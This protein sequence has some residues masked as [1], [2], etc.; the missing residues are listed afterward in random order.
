M[1][2]PHP[3]S[4]AT[5]R[6]IARKDGAFEVEVTIPDAPATRVTGL[7]TKADAERWIAKHK[8]HVAAGWPRRVFFRRGSRASSDKRTERVRP[9]ERQLRA[10]QAIQANARGQGGDLEVFVARECEAFGWVT[11]VDGVYRLTEDGTRQ[12]DERV[13]KPAYR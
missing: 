12:L 2:R 6:L 1:V 10:L 4:G 7:G 3:H 9:N 11:K 8:E 13:R 5:Y